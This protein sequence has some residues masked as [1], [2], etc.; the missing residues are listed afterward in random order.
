MRSH[1]VRAATRAAK[2][3]QLTS[4][5][6]Y[7]ATPR[8][9]GPLSKWPAILEYCRALGFDHLACAPLFAP[10]TSG[11]M[12]LTA[13]HEILNPAL[14]PDL[15]ADQTVRRL[16][17]LCCEHG[18]GLILDVVLDRVAVESP[19]SASP[20]DLFRSP[21]AATGIP[22]PRIGAEHREAIAA[23]TGPAEDRSR[24]A[25]W[26]ADRLARL[27][28][29]G[30]SGFRFL[31]APHFGRDSWDR[32]TGTIHAALRDCRVLMWTPGSSWADIAQLRGLGFDGVFSSVAWWDGRASWL[33]EEHEV[34]RRVAPVLACPE[35]PLA[36]RLAT[37]MM[38]GDN[39]LD[40]YRRALRV[41]AATGNGV[42]VPMGFEFAWRRTID[43]W[44]S[45]EDFEDARANADIDL[46]DDVRQ[47]NRLV[48][49]LGA[50][51]VTGESRILTGPDDQVTALLRCDAPDVRVAHH[52]VVVLVNPDPKL[53]RTAPRV[54]PTLPTAGAAFG[55]AKCLVG[56][57]DPHAPIRGG[58]VRIIHVSRSGDINLP[59]GQLLRLE[60]ALSASRIVI[61]NVTPS[62]DQGHYAAKRVVGEE[63]TVEADIFV[64]GHEVLAAEV[65]WCAADERD[66]S[67]QAMQALGNDRWR[68]TLT[69]SRIGPHIFTIEAWI[70]GYASLCRDLEVKR[71]A[72]ADFALE[73]HEVRA[74][75]ADVAARAPID[76]K[77]F[78]SRIADETIQA[79]S[80]QRLD[81]ILDPRT[82]AAVS[83]LARRAQTRY[84][85]ELR[86]EVERPQ[87]GFSS[88]YELFP[89]SASQDPNRHGTFDDVIRLLPSIRAMGFDVLYLPPIH[90]IGKTNRKGRNNALRAAPDDPGSPYAIGSPEGGHEAIHPQL[91]TID[92]FRR[93]RA[94]AVAEGLEIAL[95]FAVQ[96]SP[97]H[98]WITRRPDWFRFRPDGSI[99]FAENPPKKYEDIVNV[100][101]HSPNADALWTALRDVVQHWID[102]GIRLFRV[103]NPHTKPLPFWEWLIADIRA[104]HPDVIFLSEAFTRPKMMYRLAKLGFSQSYTYFTWRNTKQELTEYLT[105]LTTTDV[106][107][108]FRPHFFVNTPDINPYFLQSSGRP[109]FLIRA[110]LA[111]TLSPLWGMY[112]GFELCE[113]EPLPGRE[114]YLD[115]EKYQLRAR[116]FSAAGNIVAEITLLNRLRR[117]HPALQSGH[118]LRFYNA[119][120]DRILVY[121]RATPAN[122]DKVMVAINLDPHLPQ[123]ASFEIPLWEWGLPDH[124]SLTVEDL[125]RGHR[126]VWTGKLQHVRLDP[127]DLPFA[128]WHVA[129]ASGD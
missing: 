89:R 34:L 60:P 23:R 69:P 119:Y 67:R 80:E 107:E 9:M 68:S 79:G 75:V 6:I 28:G 55:G 19:L 88:W 128:I 44:L 123:E 76:A 36:H 18:L 84:H 87:A 65:L 39:L 4:P 63:I 37:R 16:A 22:D 30:V 72:G 97:D 122:T 43:S 27:A 112:S 3:G 102:E 12:F 66:W 45:R 121:G 104:H 48:D 116:D 50:L 57:G 14:G 124:G 108:Y 64:D 81:L 32:I 118:G 71:A 96:C 113:S 61:E 78:L 117:S 101:F 111:A 91:G 41:A 110:A 15:D 127:A 46:S 13:N 120:N 83:P 77:A 82:R 31:R 40:A 25:G 74:L 1:D 51:S 92:D 42:L 100:D 49:R 21:S 7:Y 56:D 93:L 90:P 17:G 85:P 73:L 94:A 106:K 10:G 98:P 35:P 114:E 99:R 129:P 52:G 109:G 38:P 59:D 5:K 62:V 53:S 8:L 70:D 125:I 86:I 115:S 47:A 54:D 20:H 11:D 33:V 26:W 105:E 103:D 2:L 95:D 58:E 24:L 126:F 29:A